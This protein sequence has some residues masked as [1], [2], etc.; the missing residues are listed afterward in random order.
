VE[1]IYHMAVLYQIL[2]CS[3]VFGITIGYQSSQSKEHRP[4]TIWNGN[5]KH[6]GESFKKC[7]TFLQASS[8]DD[9]EFTL[10][11]RKELLD[12]IDT[13]NTNRKASWVQ[14]IA[15]NNEKKP[16]GFFGAESRGAKTIVIDDEAQKIVSMIEDMAQ[17]NP[18]EIPVR[19][20]QG[21]KEVRMNTNEGC[22]C[23]FRILLHISIDQLF[24]DD[25]R[26]N[27]YLKVSEL[28]D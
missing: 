3:I 19:G 10:M 2:L 20:F 13:Y 12:A 21:Y 9:E 16:R 7:A 4:L 11:K 6:S 25:F 22:I 5:T 23:T 28:S 15:G 17:Y 14:E 8:N 1:Y 24:F 26:R 18:T 27:V